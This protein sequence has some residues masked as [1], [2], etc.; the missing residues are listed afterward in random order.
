[1]EHVEIGLNLT[2]ISGS[3]GSHFDLIFRQIYGQ[4]FLRTKSTKVTNGARQ[5]AILVISSPHQMLYYEIIVLTNLVV[6]D[7]FGRLN[8]WSRRA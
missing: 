6:F 2:E 7:I 3:R 1:L 5:D 4:C 8:G